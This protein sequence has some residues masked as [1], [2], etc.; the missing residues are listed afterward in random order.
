MVIKILRGLTPQFT[1]VVSS[2]VEVKN[3]NKLT[4]DEFSGS[5]KSHESI[6]NIAGEQE[7]EKSLHIKS[8][9]F[10]ESSRHGG[11]GRGHGF[12]RGRGRG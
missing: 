6:L 8:S 4:V 12:Y 7:E 11:R 9:P 1:N 5:L 3:L 10:G 2:I